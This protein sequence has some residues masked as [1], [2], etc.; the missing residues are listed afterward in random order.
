MS[1]RRYDMCHE[2]LTRCAH[3]YIVTNTKSG[4]L[5]QHFVACVVPPLV[6]LAPYLHLQWQ[7]LQGKA[8][9]CTYFSTSSKHYTTF[10]FPGVSE[11]VC[12]QAN[13]IP[14]PVN[15]KTAQ[16][17]INEEVVALKYCWDLEFT[18]LKFDRVLIYFQFFSHMLQCTVY[19]FK[20]CTKWPRLVRL[21]IFDYSRKYKGA[22]IAVCST[23][24]PD[25]THTI[26]CEA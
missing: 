21:L 10:R 1:Q 25:T 18:P 7:T 4:T 22:H 5:S 19:Y 13:T 15:R 6:K 26:T 12:N 16:W 24:P 23:M 3:L 20:V 9:T 14:L 11:N 17:I 2:M 8:H